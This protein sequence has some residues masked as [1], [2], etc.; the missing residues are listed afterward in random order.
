[1]KCPKCSARIS[2]FNVNREFICKDCGTPLTSNS[3]WVIAIAV[4]VA[5]IAKG[6]LEHSYCTSS[7]SVPVPWQS[8]VC[9]DIIMLVG[10]FG[11]GCL[12]L[13]LFIRVKTR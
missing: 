12:I 4:F 7:G 3:G 8:V 11:I 10:I 9:N 2:F 13:P 1:M 5:L 6:L